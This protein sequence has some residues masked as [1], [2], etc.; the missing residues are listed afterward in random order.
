MSGCSSDPVIT[1]KTDIRSLLARLPVYI[2]AMDSSVPSSNLLVIE[3]QIIAL[4]YIV[5]TTYALTCIHC[6]NHGS[7]PCVFTSMLGSTLV[8]YIWDT[9]VTLDQEVDNIWS[10]PFGLPQFV[11][12]LNRYGN[13]VCMIF[14]NYS[15]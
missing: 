14:A 6:A 15:K 13:M 7:S 1:N 8:I 4:R 9:L 2:I 10:A 11:F 5:G 12:F 3:D